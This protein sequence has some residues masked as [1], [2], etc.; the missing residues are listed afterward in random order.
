MSALL[1]CCGY[2]CGF[3]AAVGIYFFIVISIMELRINP[4]IV[5]EYNEGNARDKA[6]AFA[7]FAII[8]IVLVVAC[9]A[10]GRH[11]AQPPK[12]EVAANGQYQQLAAED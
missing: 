5:E 8:E 9:C 3:T 12:E 6:I 7:I 4:F 2:Y 11:Y 10:C 1:C